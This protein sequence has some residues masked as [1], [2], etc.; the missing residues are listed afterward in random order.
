MNPDLPKTRL[1]V[2]TVISIALFL[3]ALVARA[4]PGTRTID[5]AYIT[6]R[7]TRNILSGNGFVYNPGER[8][9]GT[10]T[11][12]YT[13]LLAL[14]ALPTG[15][16]Q[17]PFPVLAMSINALA[18]GLTCLLLLR[19][20]RRLGF[21]WAGLGAALV[22][23]IAPFSVTFAIGGL[24]TSVYVLLLVALAYAHL[25][26]RHILAAGL[27]ALSLLTR[28]DALLLIGPLALDRAWQFIRPGKEKLSSPGL[29]PET[30]TND[31][32]I[33][34][35][36]SAAIHIPAFRQ[37]SGPLI[38]EALAFLLPAATWAIFS[39]AYFGSPIPHSITAKSV[40]YH[41]R[42][43]EGL[44]RLLQ[45]YTTPFQ[46]DLTFGLRWIGVGLV[47]YPFLYLVGARNALRVSSRIWPFALYPWLYLAAFAIANP[48]IFRWYL[49]P[50]LPALFLFIL[51]GAEQIITGLAD[52]VARKKSSRRGRAPE[53]VQPGIIYQIVLL[54]FVVLLPAALAA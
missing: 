8:V 9:L 51:A 14:A 2:T 25:I 45:H 6:F 28:P 23:A 22:W 46:E 3:F 21:P 34:P 10:T 53:T 36:S 24:E 39:T 40:A 16:A 52:W 15:G 33:S 43:E 41:L 49:T 48:L 19:L 11:P 50:P 27:A 30:T 17:A 18:D 13:G 47:L 31:A 26:Q 5:D 42:P 20:G 4:V 1:S 54:I 29:P 12:L 44:I 37:R 32:R 7:Y 38:I 35:R